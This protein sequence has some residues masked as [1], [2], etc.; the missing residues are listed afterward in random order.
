MSEAVLI[1]LITFLAGFS[2]AIVGAISTYKASTLN[3]KAEQ[4]RLLHNE[5]KTAYTNVISAYL[6][7]IENIADI[8]TSVEHQESQSLIDAMHQFFAAYATAVL[9]APNE[10]K[11]AMKQA[12]DSLGLMIKNQQLSQDGELFEQL[13]ELMRDDLYSLIHEVDKKQ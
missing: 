10:I 8:E 13:T 3:A 7:V 1:A 9:I 12:G 4:G 5:K 6:C 2:G 11:T